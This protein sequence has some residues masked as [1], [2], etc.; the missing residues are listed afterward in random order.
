M[1]RYWGSAMRDA[2]SWAVVRAA[3]SAVGAT[4]RATSRGCTIS[5]ANSKPQAIAAGMTVTSIQIAFGP[6]AAIHDPISHQTRYALSTM[7]THAVIHPK[8]RTHRGLANAPIRAF[9]W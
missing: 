1:R 6:A 9:R 7:I 3:D 8:A 4:G 2:T 5:H